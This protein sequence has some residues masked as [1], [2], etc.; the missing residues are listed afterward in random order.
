MAQFKFLPIPTE[1]YDALGIDSG[2]VLQTRVTDDGTLIV[3]TLSGE[4]LE[5]FICDGDCES[6]PV[7]EAD[8]DG[9]CFSCPCYACCDDSEYLPKDGFCKSQGVRR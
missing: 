4:D 5:E 1:D 9:D 6:C 7:A 3:R 2:T 8:C